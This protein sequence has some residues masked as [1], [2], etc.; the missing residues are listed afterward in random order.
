[1][2]QKVRQLFCV[3]TVYSYVALCP[4]K[5][6]FAHLI[7]SQSSTLTVTLNKALECASD[8]SV[9]TIERYVSDIM[10]V[11]VDITQ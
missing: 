8:F 5:L 10:T 6:H 4:V 1:M 2:Y 11:K 9:S 7:R 3:V